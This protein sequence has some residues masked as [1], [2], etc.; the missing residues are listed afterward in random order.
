[1]KRW[2]SKWLVACT[3][4]VS[5]LTI[6]PASAAPI[7]V[8]DD[9]GTQLTLNRPAER[10]VVLCDFA[11]ELVSALEA[12]DLVVGRAR[13]VNWPPQIAAR[14][15]LGLSAQPNLEL[16]LNWQ[17]DLVLADSHSRL[18][19][20]LL[21]KFKLP[22]MVYQ[23]NSMAQIKRAVFDFSR[24]LNRQPQGQKLMNFIEQVEAELKPLASQP[25]RQALLAFAQ[26][27]P[28][29]YNLLAGHAWLAQARLDNLISGP[30]GLGAEG[31][32][33]LKPDLAILALWQ[34]GVNNT[35]RQALRASQAQLRQ[36]P[37]VA[38][39]KNL[40]L[41]DSRLLY[42]LQALA[43][44][45]YLAKWCHPQTMAGLQPDVYYQR[46]RQEFFHLPPACAPVYP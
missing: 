37:E 31:F 45:L 41:I 5:L 19:L 38:A 25:P 8:S 15:H 9:L 13:W 44:A 29:Y 42:N 28:P 16:L 34:P 23:G 27:G 3:A 22:V 46:L 1:M 11:A 36:R 21:Q 35:A 39:V 6:A 33:L 43:G 4:L 14:P 7:T 10:I 18:S 24:A 12:D 26:H 40:H 32:M 17:P 30:G 20:P 2:L